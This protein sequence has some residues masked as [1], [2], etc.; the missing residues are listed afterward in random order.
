MADNHAVECADKLCREIMALTDP[1]LDK[2]EFGGKVAIFAG[3]WRQLLPVVVHGGRAQ[4]I[5][6][7]LKRSTLWVQC[8]FRER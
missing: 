2:V 1:E 6:A 8:T 5:N 3:D 4:I 7:S